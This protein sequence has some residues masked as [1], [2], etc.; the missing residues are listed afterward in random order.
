MKTNKLYFLPRF[1]HLSYKKNDPI[2]VLQLNGFLQ[3][4]LEN[5][6]LIITTTPVQ[7]QL[8]CKYVMKSWC[9]QVRWPLTQH[10]T[11]KSF[12]FATSTNWKVRDYCR[13]PANGHILGPLPYFCNDSSLLC[14][15]LQSY[16][17]NVTR[18]NIT[19]MRQSLFIFSAL[20]YKFKQP[21]IIFYK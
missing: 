6:N 15:S 11:L 18:Q 5:N 21:L 2:C 12:Q 13:T 9:K 10:E 16:I 7:K 8:W 1:H 3:C 19:N 4:V 14:V 17:Y 20:K